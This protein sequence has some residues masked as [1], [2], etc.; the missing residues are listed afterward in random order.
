MSNAVECA[1]KYKN[2]RFVVHIT[3][4]NNADIALDKMINLLIETPN[5]YLEVYDLQD[6]F[7]LNQQ[8][9][10]KDY[11][12]PKLFYHY[13]ANTY[14]MIYYLKNLNVS[15]IIL[16]EPIVFDLVEVRKVVP[17]DSGIILRALPAMGRP[18]MFNSIVAVDD[19]LCHFWAVP[20]S[21]E[22]YENYIDLFDLADADE[23]REATLF[24]IFAR[25]SY[26]HGLN[27]FCNNVDNQ[28]SCDFFSEDDLKYRLTCKQRCMKNQCHRCRIIADMY[29]RLKDFKDGTKANK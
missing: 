8:L 1:L 6:L 12:T 11:N 18:P 4:L 9:K 14:N 5:L 13:P 22:L 20:Q 2:K 27:S 3:N 23:T 16:G 19:G 29:Q 15:D 25:G 28:V 24:A 7:N 21:I 26:I 10:L 17:K